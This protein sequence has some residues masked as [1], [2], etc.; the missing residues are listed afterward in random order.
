[1]CKSATC[2][3]VMTP[4]HHDL[5]GLPLLFKQRDSTGAWE[6]Q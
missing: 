1:M 6:W 2:K 5:C 3:S 4:H